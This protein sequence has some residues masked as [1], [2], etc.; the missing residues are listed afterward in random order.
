MKSILFFPINAFV[1]DISYIASPASIGHGSGPTSTSQSA[2][3]S[4]S[5]IELP[6]YDAGDSLPIDPLIKH[7]CETFFAHLGCNFPF[8]QRDR[9]IRDLEEKKVDAILVDAVCA[10]AAR[11]STHPLLLPPKSRGHGEAIETGEDSH[12]AHQGSPFAHRAMSAVVETF[13]YPTIAVVQ[14][15]LLLAYEEFGCNHDSGLWMYVGIAIRMA[16][17][18]G[19]QKLEGLKYEGRR[20]PTPKTAKSAQAGRAEEARRES[21]QKEMDASSEDDA[22][23]IENQRANERE[24]LDTFWSVFFLDRVISI[25]TGRPVTLRDKDIE[26]SFPSD[27]VPADGWPAPFPP[28][29]RII[30]LYGRVTDLLNRIKEVNNVTPETIKKLAGMETDLTGKFLLMHSTM[31]YANSKQASTSDSHLSFIS[32]LSISSTTSRLSKEPTSS[33]SISGFMF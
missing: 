26:I 5:A 27:T 13:P 19:M 3:D 8:L 32:M 30:H 7:L 1:S 18:L 11:F 22:D 4:E 31:A 24:R 33:F 17:D 6:F 28:L 2:I 25:G 21:L 10:V 15:C 29:I 9:F 23:S 12:K 14:A 16:Q 20:G